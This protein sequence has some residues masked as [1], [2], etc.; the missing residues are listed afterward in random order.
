MKRTKYRVSTYL[1]PKYIKFI[2]RKAREKG[3]TVSEWLRY[4][5]MSHLDEEMKKENYHDE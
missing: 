5:L 1:T 4:F 3:I 2:E